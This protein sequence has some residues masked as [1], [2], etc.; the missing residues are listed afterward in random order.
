MATMLEDIAEIEQRK[1]NY[2]IS[3]TEAAEGDVI[4]PNEYARRRA[5]VVGEGTIVEY[6]L[7][8]LVLGLWRRL[9]PLPVHDGVLVKSK[10]D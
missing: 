6:I 9:F 7:I 3:L 2:T 1:V 10:V 5:N 4:T 8:P